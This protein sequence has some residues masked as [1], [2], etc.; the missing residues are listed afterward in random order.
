VSGHQGED[1]FVSWAPIGWMALVAS[2]RMIVGDTVRRPGSPPAIGPLIG[3]ISATHLSYRAR[4]AIPKP[5]S[6]V[7][8]VE[9]VVTDE[10][11]EAHRLDLPHPPR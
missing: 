4:H 9:A 11:P 5:L 10:L 3:L 8:S 6:A 2:T 7:R 1:Q